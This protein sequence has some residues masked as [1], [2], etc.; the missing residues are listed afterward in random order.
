MT[1]EAPGL[2]GFMCANNEHSGCLTNDESVRLHSCERGNY[3]STVRNSPVVWIQPII[4]HLSG[5]TDLVEI[6]V[7]GGGA[8][9][10]REAEMEF[11]APE[12]IRQLLQM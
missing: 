7:G 8:D 6:G 11:L 12:D 1:A 10:E 4:A 2:V 9:L 3:C 5:G